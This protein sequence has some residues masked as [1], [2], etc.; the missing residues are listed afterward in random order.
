M[1]LPLRP[2]ALSVPLLLLCAC[3]G[4]LGGPAGSGNGLNHAPTADAGGD[5]AILES[6]LVTLDGTHSHD[7]DADPLRYRWSLTE[8]PAQSAAALDDPRAATPTFFV[9]FVGV[10]RV[11]LVVDDGVAESAP[12]DITLT[13]GADD[14]LRVGPTRALRTPSEA[15]AVAQDGAVIRIDAGTYRG[16]VAT[17]A[18]NDLRIVGSGGDVRLLA[19]GQSAQG[20]AIWVVQGS[21]TTI[22][23]ISF[24]GCQ[25]NDGNGA[26]IRLEGGDLTVRRCRFLRNQMGFLCGDLTQTDLYF[27]GCEFGWSSSTGALAHGIY[28]NRAH[29]LE[30]RNCFV[31]D[32]SR[33]HCIKSRAEQTRILWCRVGDFAGGSSSYTIDIPDGGLAFLIG[34]VIHKGRNSQNEIAISFAEEHSGVHPI[35]ALYVA[36]DT[37]VID[38]S[39]GFFVRAAHGTAHLFDNVFCGPGGILEG[40][41]EQAGN[42]DS[43]TPGFVDRAGYDFRLAPG[44]AAIDAGIAAGGAYGTA[45]VPAFEYRDVATCVPRVDGGAPDVGAFAFVATP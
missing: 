14:A 27:E 31:H 45:L 34:N 20:K 9:D 11:R 29:A 25:V 26:G 28:V 33:G 21:D 36:H 30:M 44:S 19:D 8:R 17:I 35:D 39:S 1:H 7:P 13:A 40:Q 22:E 2:S 18:R 3:A 38:R 10:Y 15:F 6:D 24:E 37:V 41:G 16:D 23:G 42:L 5:R 32:A 43:D 4:G 12:V